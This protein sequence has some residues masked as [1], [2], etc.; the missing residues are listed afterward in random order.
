MKA[1]SYNPN[2]PL[3][4]PGTRWIW[5]INNPN[6][7]A[8]VQV[9][10]V[11]WNGEEWWVTTSTLLPRTESSP[12]GAESLAYND[13]SRFWEACIP[14]LPKLTGR[15]DTFTERRPPTKDMPL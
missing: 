6:A 10:E 14:V 9:E 5:E 11:T 3:P 13:L 7:R 4:K 1:D 8:L 2:A 15:M 12:P